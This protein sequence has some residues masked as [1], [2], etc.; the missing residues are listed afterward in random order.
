MDSYI[1]GNTI[2]A[3]REK[4]GLTQSQLAER[5][6]VSDKT[7]SKWETGRGLPDIT[8]IEPLA[9]SLGISV[10][11]LMAGEA[12]INS[13]R[14]ASVARSSFYVCPVCGNVIFSVGETAISC[15]GV[16][17]KPLSAEKAA[18]IHDFDVQMIDGEYFVSS[19]HP[20]EKD[21]FVSFFAAVSCDR[22]QIL[23]LY[24][25]GNAEGRLMAAGRSVF[26]MFCNREGLF[27][28]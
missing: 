6:A 28:K 2:R 15:C 5:I 10:G 20:M 23:K 3:L 13:N 19:S 1:T 16:S 4:K 17:L 7:V 25:E 9:S 12:L 8:L 22:A 18:G 24:P 21:H 26:Y 11:E 14:C 27:Y